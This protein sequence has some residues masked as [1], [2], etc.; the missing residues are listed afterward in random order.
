MEKRAAYVEGS[1]DSCGIGDGHRIARF[2]WLG[3]SLG[4]RGCCRLLCRCLRACCRRLRGIGGESDGCGR[5]VSVCC[6]IGLVVGRANEC[7]VH[8]SWAGISK[9]E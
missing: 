3:G 4:R 7:L 1:D 5:G 8:P 9:W 6:S 2:S